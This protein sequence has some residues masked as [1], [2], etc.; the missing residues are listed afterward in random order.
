V[1]ALETA[2]VG[3]EVIFKGAQLGQ[4]GGYYSIRKAKEETFPRRYGKLPARRL[5]R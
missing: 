4:S 1:K 2:A 5:V 3:E